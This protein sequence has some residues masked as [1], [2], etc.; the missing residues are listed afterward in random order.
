MPLPSTDACERSRMVYRSRMLA[1]QPP[2]RLRSAILRRVRPDAECVLCRPRL[3]TPVV[4]R[5]RYWRIVI[6]RNQNLLGKTMIVLV[7]HEE[8]VTALS[9]EEW[10]ELQTELRWLTGQLRHAFSPDHFNY[11]FLQNSD[12]HI[13]LHVIPRYA[14]PR[15][16]A[17]CEFSDPDYPG[18]YTP[19]VE[20]RVGQ[21]V[22]EAIANAIG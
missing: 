13:H 5:S 16:F 22:Y 8:P 7:R 20:Q 9:P 17:G 2:N 18:H 15:S 21:E 1:A 4:R 3:E 6:N 12:R 10:S 11:A 19:G 14:R